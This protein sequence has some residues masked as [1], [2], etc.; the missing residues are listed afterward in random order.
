MRLCIVTHNVL[1]GDGQGRVNYEV[2]QAAIRRGDQVTLV[3]IE[4]SPD[5][6][7]HPQIH[8]IK[9]P[10]KVPTILG[11][12][13]IFSQKSTAWLKQHRDEFDLIKVNGSLTSVN[14]DVNAVHF[15]HSSWLRSPAHISRHRR[16]YYGTYQWLYTWLNAYW[17]K[18][19]FRRSK[20]MVAVS[21]KVKQELIELGVPS[22]RIQVILNG[23][24]VQEFSP[25]VGERRQ[26]HLPEAVPLGLFVG[27]IRS[28]RKN[29]D[30]VLKALVQ[31]PQLH[32]AVVGA[33]EGSPYLN[34]AAQ[35]NLSDRVH[36]LGYQ[37][38]V[39]EI[40]H[41][42]DFFVLPSRYEA[43]TL[44][45]LEAM[46][47]G[48]PIITAKTAGGSEIVTP[49]CGVVLSDSENVENLA[50]A[51]QLMTVDSSQRKQMGQV[52]RTIAEQHT[53]SKAADL[54]VNLFHQMTQQPTLSS[55]SQS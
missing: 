14:S 35:L 4:V 40:M 34:Y 42:A 17:E 51:L 28:S 38:N 8:W 39:A 19:A 15:V 26:W 54:Y 21:E 45:L 12:C 36:F 46:A 37:K 23:V 13:M 3:A 27:D 2:V 31:V 6:Q 7:Q 16:D 43:C 33:I 11:K 29:L 25:G 24:D 5:L 44:V 41:T 55:Q 50:E 10:V 9:I 22:T 47:S 1:K 52:A 30:T 32:L 20:K 53:W 48:L 18:Q 49:D